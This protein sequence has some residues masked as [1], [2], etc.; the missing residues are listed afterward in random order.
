[1]EQYPSRD[2]D[3][4]HP[5]GLDW[6]KLLRRLWAPIGILIGLSIKFGAFAIKFFG[7]FISVG[8]Y[9]LIWGWRFA[10]GIVLLIL[11]HEA[12]HYF[13]ARRQGLSPSLPT[14]VPFL[15]A[16]V[17][18]R[19]A[20]DP[21]QGAKIAIMGPFIGGLGALACYVAGDVYDSR[22]LLAL[23]YTG[24]LL[25]LFN[26]IPIVPFDGGAIVQSARLIS[27]AG[28]YF[29]RPSRPRA[30]LLWGLYLGLGA[31]LALGMWISHVPQDRL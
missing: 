12:G 31:A 8:A 23:A 25:N 11:V 1:M 5:G 21:W 10:I 3:P 22:L 14:F 16:Y 15:G 17:T 29:G 28:T 18:F 7:I 13:E 26:L 30:L 6:R 19:A 20:N 27:H 2:Y 4:I 9:A 24:F